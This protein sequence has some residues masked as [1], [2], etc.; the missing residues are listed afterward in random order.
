MAFFF[1]ESP[2]LW[3]AGT[4]DQVPMAVRTQYVAACT[5]YSSLHL[6][7]SNPKILSGAGFGWHKLYD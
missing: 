2:G 4:D 5:Q 3:P 7:P 1:M 6:A